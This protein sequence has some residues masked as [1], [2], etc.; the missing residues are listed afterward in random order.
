M[1]L[2]ERTPKSLLINQ[3]YPKGVQKDSSSQTILPLSI[4]PT[5]TI[6]FGD[7]GRGCSSGGSVVVANEDYV[8]KYPQGVLRKAFSSDDFSRAANMISFHDHVSPPTLLFLADNGQS[9]VPLLLQERVKGQP[10]CDTPLSR[11]LTKATLDSLLNIQENALE[12]FKKTSAVD[13]CGTRIKTGLWSKVVNII[14]IFGDNILVDYQG[15]CILVDNFPRNNIHQNK[16]KC[17]LV[18]LCLKGGIVL[19]RFVTTIVDMTTKN[20]FENRY[21]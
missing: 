3:F 16:A 17:A 13:L 19:N 12:V 21:F 1:K 20:K 14:P 11:I 10:I 5:E 18:K 8:V 7:W 4:F 15:K 9:P 2:L 6:G